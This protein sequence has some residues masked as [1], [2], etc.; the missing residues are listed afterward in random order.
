[1]NRA[2]KNIAVVKPVNMF[3]K[4]EE[5]VYLND[6][7]LIVVEFE[8]NSRRILDIDNRVDITDYKEWV[9]MIN[10]NSKVDYIF[11]GDTDYYD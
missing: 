1:M 8:D 9:P 6:S 7:G 3:N 10:G 2:V 5:A 11:K 4:E